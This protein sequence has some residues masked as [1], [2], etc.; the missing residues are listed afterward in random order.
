MWLVIL[1]L[2]PAI[3]LKEIAVKANKFT[4]VSVN[5]CQL[6]V[7][8]KEDLILNLGI[9]YCCLEEVL[10]GDTSNTKI[11]SATWKGMEVGPLSDS[12]EMLRITFVFS[13]TLC[14]LPGII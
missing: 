8:L 14:L 4:S 6:N 10:P 3:I 9:Y 11:F 12:N 2:E 1:S 5:K 7:I 13:T